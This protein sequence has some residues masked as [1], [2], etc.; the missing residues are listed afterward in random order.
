MKM[1]RSFLLLMLCY[2]VV[3]IQVEAK[4][5]AEQR[6]FPT[7]I[8]MRANVLGDCVNIRSYPDIEANIISN[9]NQEEIKVIGQNKKWYK[10]IAK[11]KE[12][13]VYK[14]YVKVHRPERI[15]Y[16]KVEGE[17]IIE[18]GLQFLGTP[19]VWGGTDLKSGVDCSGF[20][21]EV[22]KAFD[23]SIS[24]VSYMQAT[25]GKHIDKEKL[26]SGDLIFFDTSGVNN[27]KVSHVGIYI[28]ENKFL[29]SDSTHGVM[30]SSLDSTYYTRNYVKAMRVL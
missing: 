15:P 19:Y 7:Y 24:R 20:T 1:N 30:V 29:H 12:G 11:G 10:V 14:D 3:S 22:F 23:V 18:Y 21:Q 8:G 2:L 5:Q 25:E 28:G 16:A 27:G 6:L 13:W 4:P 17:Y 9:M 26:Q